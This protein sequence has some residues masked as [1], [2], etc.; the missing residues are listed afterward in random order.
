MAEQTDPQ[1]HAEPRPDRPKMPEGYGVPRSN[2]GTLPW[3]WAV[4]RLEGALNYWIGTTRPDGRPHAVPVWGAVV[5]GTVYFEGGPDTR[6]GRNIAANPAVVV[7][8]EQGNDIV[9]VEGTAEE[10]TGPGPSLTAQLAEAFAAKYGPGYDYRP[11]ADQWNEGGLYVVR[12][13]VV[14]AWSKFPQDATRWRF[15]DD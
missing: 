6:R 15:G 8:I 4:E 7:H 3:S 5:D 14:F 2:E 12:P 10:I 1:E 13:H 11:T 9:I